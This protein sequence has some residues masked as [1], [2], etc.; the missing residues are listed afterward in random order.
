MNESLEVIVEMIAIVSFVATVVNYT[1]IKPLRLSIDTLTHAVE[2]IEKLLHQLEDEE[3][4]LR[5]RV[6]RN[7][8]EIKTLKGDVATLKDFHKPQ[9]SG[10]KYS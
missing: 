4:R 3:V 2:K 8:T 6:I 10:G 1:I 9:P 5:E 7:E